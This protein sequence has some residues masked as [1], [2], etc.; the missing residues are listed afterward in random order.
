MKDPLHHDVVDALGAAYEKMY[1]RAVQGF[2][3]SEEKTTGLLH[4][5]IDD[6]RDTAVELGE[7]SRE[8]AEK[9]STYVKRDLNDTLAYLSETGRDLKDWLGFETIVLEAGFLEMLKEAADPTTLAL[10]K[11][12]Q[13]AQ[14]ASIYQTGEITGPGT[15]VCDACGENLH[16]HKTGRIPPCPKC[17]KTSFHRQSS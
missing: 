4:K 17:H 1:E 10:L 5:L 7:V 13:D 14:L 8:D 3:K 2:H 12:K 15:L 9:L 6:A 16:F 11:L